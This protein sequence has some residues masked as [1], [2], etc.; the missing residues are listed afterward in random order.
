MGQA[1]RSIELEWGLSDPQIE[2]F[3]ACE[4]DRLHVAFIGGINSGKTHWGALASLEHICLHGEPGEEFWI[5]NRSYKL[6]KSVTFKAFRHVLK[7]FAAQS[8]ISP[9]IIA[10]NKQERTITLWN[11]VIVRMVT[12]KD[13]REIQGVSLFGAWGDEF[14][15]WPRES[16]E[17][18]IKRIRHPRLKSQCFWTTTL[19]MS[20][21][22]VKEIFGAHQ[23][24]PSHWACIFAPTSDAYPWVLPGYTE[25]VRRTMSPNRAAQALDCNWDVVGAFGRI[26]QGFAYDQHLQLYRPRPTTRNFLSIDFGFLAPH[27]L[28]IANNGEDD[29]DRA[30]DVVYDEEIGV[31]VP[32]PQFCDNILAKLARWKVKPPEA[33]YVDPAG[34]ARNEQTQETNVDILRRKFPNSQ[35][36]WVRRAVLTVKENQWEFIRWR[37]LTPDAWLMGRKHAEPGDGHPR[38]FFSS[39]LDRTNPR[40]IVYAMDNFRYHRDRNDYYVIGRYDQECKPQTHAVDALCYYVANRYGR[41]HQIYQT[42]KDYTREG[43]RG[44][45][46]H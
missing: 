2:A 35:V 37:L 23:T 8:G 32:L 38:I 31:E 18:L 1:A 4:S 3:E 20:S 36:K 30:R 6:L 25:M 27:A 26:F 46:S 22:W 19:A 9:A 29:W 15:S 33:I 14:A 16:V 13:P 5:L 45:V 41:A 43:R 40:A 17:N 7:E 21:P 42:Q 11:G 28:F 34:T 10:E 39:T 24:D 12:T 44:R